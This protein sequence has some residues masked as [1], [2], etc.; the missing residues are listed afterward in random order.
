MFLF[1][2]LDYLD[3]GLTIVV[4]AVGPIWHEGAN[5][6]QF[7]LKNVVKNS[8]EKIDQHFSSSKEISVAI[9]PIS[10]GIFHYP[11]KDATMIITETVLEYLTKITSSKIKDIKLISNEIDAVKI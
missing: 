10:T 3:V 7:K 4:N 1:R 9:P 2:M 8:L 6:E 11:K 5:N